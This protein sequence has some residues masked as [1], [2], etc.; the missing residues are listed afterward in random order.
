MYAFLISLY[1]TTINFCKAIDLLLFDSEDFTTVTLTKRLNKKTASIEIVLKGTVDD[2]RT[3]NLKN[4]SLCTHP[5]VSDDVNLAKCFKTVP[6][7]NYLTH[8]W[9]QK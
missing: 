2:Y 1:R 9:Q 5:N 6:T 7:M 4:K 3:L 8:E